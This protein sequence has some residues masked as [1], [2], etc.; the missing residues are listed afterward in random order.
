MT[1]AQ[2][3]G[4]EA[5]ASRRAA[6]RVLALPQYD[7]RVRQELAQR[8][9]LLAICRRAAVVLTLVVLDA[10][11]VLLAAWGAARVIGG[12]Q[13]RELAPS[14]VGLVLLALAARMTYRRGAARR[15][16][17]RLLSAV[18]GAI[19]GLVLLSALPPRVELPVDFVLTF[20][21]LTA[22]GLI[23]VRS[24]V[25]LAFRE[26]YARGI[27]LRKAV[28]VGRRLDVESL[29]AA[30]QE[31]GS[32]D[33]QIVGYL[34]PSRV[35]ESGALGTIEDL[36]GI[37]DR[38]D[39]AELIVSATLTPE[40]LRR[41]ANA[42]VRRGT[43][44]LAVPSWGHGIRGWAE[45]VK[46]GHLPAYHLHPTRLG[47]PSLLL[48]RAC[49]L[50]LTTVSLIGL[51]PV[52]ALIAVMIKIESRGPVFF[53]Q[54]RVGL[55][56]REFM[57]WKFRSMSHEAERREPEVAH[58]NPYSDGRLFKLQHDPR[59]TRAGRVLRRLSLDELPQLFN[60]LAGD[61]SLVGPR[62]PLPREVGK[63]EPR[64]FVRL[65]VVPG[66]TGP[67]QVSGRNLITDFE[68]VVRLEREYVE[69]W[70]LRLDLRIMAR[71]VGVVVSGEGAY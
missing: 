2:A 50:V 71:T 8:R 46:I 11:T 45:P 31:D 66:L 47:M 52:M 17:P 19:C 34:T 51:A 41:I 55:G 69:H 13:V 26:A 53:R 14:L 21:A 27:G 30:L 1:A 58:L 3:A 54:R 49:D 10:S 25:D 35:L 18:A 23:A 24:T 60:V 20:G 70:S 57:M 42:C 44:M 38:E 59:I 40:L 5:L 7:V 29:V 63:Y 37:L 68:E 6:H 32:R 15:D 61:M 62:P 28:I 22:A 16:S 39:P 33:H 12:V 9:L 4:G 64:H 65:S 67:W 48:K 43:R 36:E 56:G